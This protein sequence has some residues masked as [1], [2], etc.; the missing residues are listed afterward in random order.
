MNLKIDLKSLLK[1]KPKGEGETSEDGGSAK[2]SEGMKNAAI[3]LKA[4]LLLVVLTSVSLGALG[5]GIYFSM[6]FMD[7]LRSDAAQYGGKI[8]EFKR[9]ES[10]PV[11]IQIPGNA[12]LTQAA[13]V[14]RK[15]VDAVKSRMGSGITDTAEVRGTAVRHN[16]GVHK[17]LVNLRLD[18]KNPKR[19]EVH[20]D[21]VAALNKAYSD[22]LSREIGAG[23][24]PSEE[25]VTIKLQRRQVRFM[26]SD[27]KKA[28]DA[29]LTDTERKQL[30]ENLTAYRIALYAEAAD[31][32]RMFVDG[33]DVGMFAEGFDPAPL[34]L[35]I[36]RL[37]NLQFRFWV[38]EDIL[39]ACKA[40]NTESSLMKNPIKRVLSIQSLGA[41][42]AAG[43]A[44][45]P[46]APADDSAGDDSSGGSGD[47]SGD[48]VSAAVP[49]GI[50]IDPAQEVSLASYGASVK[51]WATN[52]L[53]DVMRTKVRMVAETSKIPQ[54]AD[55]L[56]K[57]NF[58]VITDVEIHPTDAYTGLS[59]GC[60]YGE[61]PVSS[62]TWTLESAWLREWTGPLMPDEIR[63]E[64]NTTG[65]LASSMPDGTPSAQEN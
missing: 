50:P 59:E 14:N 37:W 32:A 19:Q 34:K 49:S 35:N 4:H 28:P 5:G 41:V 60:F 65:Q 62:V 8:G 44:A 18:P 30:T 12:P 42:V 24:P 29:T 63:K 48:D 54:I 39:L 3:W 58:I 46:T 21:M 52:Q 9:L 6:E 56:A 57:Q 16:K 64:L 25:D 1:R 2:S 10:T 45:E 36:A 47:G 26:Q 55:A 27:L 43:G 31:A 33:E 7:S 22:L 53:Y 20:L 51:G 61:E 17:Q 11:T 23:A 40:V 38:V 13:V 15:L